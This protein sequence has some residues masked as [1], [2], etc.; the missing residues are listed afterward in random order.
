MEHIVKPV[1]ENVFTP[2][3]D[4]VDYELHL[5]GTVDIESEEDDREDWEGK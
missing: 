2:L 5:I 3:A 4:T 1:E